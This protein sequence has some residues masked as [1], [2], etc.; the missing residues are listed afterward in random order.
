MIR[1]APASSLLLP[2]F[3]L[4]GTALPQ[5]PSFEVASIKP[6]RTGGSYG[7]DTPPGG[8]F[9]ATNVSLKMLIQ[10]AFG[11]ADFQV[12]GG[13][14]WLGT[15]RYDIAA[16]NSVSQQIGKEE[17]KPLLQALLQ[18]RFALK[19]HRETKELPVYSLVFAKSG[20]KLTAHTG[21]GGSSQNTNSSPERGAIVARK[22]TIA[23]LAKA[24]SGLLRRPVIDNTALPGEF[25]FNLEWTPGPNSRDVWCIP[26]HCDSGTTRP[27]TRIGKRPRRNY[28]DRQHRKTIGELSYRPTNHPSCRPTTNNPNAQPRAG[29]IVFTPNAPAGRGSPIPI[30]I[31]RGCINPSQHHRQRKIDRRGLARKVD[32]HQYHHNDADSI[33]IRNQGL[34][35]FGRSG[36]AWR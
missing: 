36:L 17:F 14:G 10:A 31:L 1:T 2:L 27:E 9:A 16:K 28:R 34:S 19:L 3:L 23:N 18:D 5:S 22:T 15:E 13:P 33:R 25:D 11:V 32:R 4:V 20:P 24:L 12:A 35:D 21:T 26:F 8:R 6:N 29:T 30:A 7:M